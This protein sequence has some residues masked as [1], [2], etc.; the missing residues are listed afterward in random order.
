MAAWRAA[1]AGHEVT[2][3]R[4]CA[5]ARRDGGLVRGRRAA[6]RPRQPP[7]PPVDRAACPRRARASC[8]ATTCS[9]VRATGAS[10]CSTA[11]WRS[12]CGPATS[13]ARCR[14]GSRS[15]LRPTRSPRRC[16]G[17]RADTFAEVVRAGLGPTVYRA[18]YEP[19][20]RKLWGTDGA[21][22]AGELARRRVSATSPLDIARRLVSG[23]GARDGIDRR[24]FL[25]PRTGFGT[26]SEALAEAAEK[27]GADAAAGRGRR[28]AHASTATR[29]ECSSTRARRST[30]SAV[31]S[32]APLARCR[33]CSATPCP[34]TS[35]PRRRGSSTGRWCSSTS[36]LDR[37]RWT[38]F[39]AHYFPSL[40][41]LPARVSE[42]KALPQQRR[43]SRRPH[44]AVRR[45]R[46]QRRRRGV[47]RGR[48]RARRPRRRRPRPVRS[49]ARPTRSRW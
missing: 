4:S 42:P 23:R 41:V 46:V 13:C 21:A 2:R 31:W 32:T 35:A 40:D 43:R 1:L 33:G 44:G 22:L 24:T 47:A 27:A 19:Y 20:A 38:E 18:L 25:Y 45:G 39:D 28:G 14:R 17:P 36:S 49:A 11:G 3:G 8:S 6:R 26:I 30:R 48:R 34:T 10:A 7:P 29:G 16:G 15:G 5:G 9:C 37:P 12:R